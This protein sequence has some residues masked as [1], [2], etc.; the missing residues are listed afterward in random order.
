MGFDGVYVGLV[1][2]SPDDSYSLPDEYLKTLFGDYVN[3]IESCMA[4]AQPCRFN[5][6]GHDKILRRL[7]KGEPAYY[8]CATYAGIRMFHVDPAGDI[9]PCY[10]LVTQEDRLGNV[11]GGIPTS[12]ADR[13]RK[14]FLDNNVCENECRTCWARH[15]CGGLCPARSRRGPGFALH[16]TLRER[17]ALNLALYIRLW[18]RHRPLLDALYGAAV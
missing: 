10:R 18:R 17:M 14:A 1:D 2:S 16:C 7:Y 15:L 13:I 9:Y 8:A 3:V 11:T 4:E 12:Q 5:L 6:S